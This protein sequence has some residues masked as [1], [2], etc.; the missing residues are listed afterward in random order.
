MRERER[1]R[2]KEM[3]TEK[4]A[5]TSAAGCVGEGGQTLQ[6]VWHKDIK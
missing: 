6:E 5:E 2:E 3:E 4:E 1:E